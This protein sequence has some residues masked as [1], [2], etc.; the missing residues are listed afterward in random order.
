MAGKQYSEQFKRNAVA[1]M[2]EKGYSLGKASEALG[3]STATLA[4]WKHK[5]APRQQAEVEAEKGHRDNVRLLLLLRCSRPAATARSNT[6][7]A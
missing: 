3:V 6:G 1:L 4:D 2:A 7:D 5:L